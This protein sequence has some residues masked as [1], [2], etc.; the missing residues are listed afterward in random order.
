M[1]SIIDLAS[2]AAIAASFAIVA[3]R[4]RL[5]LKLKV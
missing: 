5:E 2:V 1:F 3:Y 4:I